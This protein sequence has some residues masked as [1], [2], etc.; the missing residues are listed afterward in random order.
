MAAM[1][2]FMTASSWDET[3]VKKWH[4]NNFMIHDIPYTIKDAK[5]FLKTEAVLTTAPVRLLRLVGASPPYN[6]CHNTR[7]SGNE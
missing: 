1:V 2:I 6:R 5:G 7:Q 4:S 3:L